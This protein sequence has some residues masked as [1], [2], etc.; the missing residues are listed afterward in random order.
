VNPYPSY[1]F[2]P[3]Q[4]AQRDR[5]RRLAW[6]SIWLLAS[7][8]L[9]MAFAVGQ[10]QSM[11]TAWISDVLSI[12]PPIA[13]LVAMRFELRTP[14]ERFPYGYTRALSVS[15][16][17]TAASLS[18]FGL[19][20]FGDAVLKL[21]RAERPPIGTVVLFGHQI[22]AGWTMVS[23]LAYSLACGMLIGRLKLPV[24]EALQDRALAAE[25][26]MN[27]DEWNSEGAA[28]LGILLVGFGFWWADSLA[29]AI[30][31][32]NIIRDAWDSVQKV[33]ADLMDEAPN[34]LDRNRLEDL[35]QRVR[36]AAERYDW[37]QQA[38]VRLREHGRLITGDV[39]VVTRDAT[40]LPER[41]ERAAQELATLDWRLHGLTMMPVR[42]L[43]PAAPP[44]TG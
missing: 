30:I 24:A 25:A 38:A 12:V 7:A 32:I 8:A 1:Q 5:A 14:S 19:M 2:P 29:A 23:A 26:K 11:K 10:S 28:I 34:V 6:F 39:F 22:W 41:I 4:A 31:S 44:Q 13:Y 15:F 40:D 9:L 43:E 17:V 3:E 35:P 42:A 27:H 21:V 33:I 20:L 18:L 16:L 36:A 37:V